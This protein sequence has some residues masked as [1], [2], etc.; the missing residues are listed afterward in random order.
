M[1]AP[2][3]KTRTGLRTTVGDAARRVGPTSIQP[4][5]LRDQRD[6]LSALNVFQY[7]QSYRLICQIAQGGMGKVYLAEALGVSGFTKTVGIKTIR[8]ELIDSRMFRDLFI[9]E[10][11]LVAD[12]VHENIQQ[13]Y[14]LVDMAGS[15]AIAMEWVHGVTFEDINSR[16]DERD[17]YLPPELAVFLTSR[18]ARALAY[19]HDK[20]DR[21]GQPMQ[22]V[23]RDVSPVNIFASWQGVVKLADFGIAKTLD[24]DANAQ[25]QQIMGKVPY[26]SPEQARGDVTDARTDIFAL[27]LVLFEMLTGEQVYPVEDVDEV[28]DLHISKRIPSPREWNPAIPASI[29]K[30]LARLCEFDPTKRYQSASE[31]VKDLEVFMY[32]GGYGPTNERLSEYLNELFPEVDKQR[33]LPEEV[34]RPR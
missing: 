27:G 23:H 34:I 31:V 25:G 16:L 33:L 3:N 15:Y 18:V 5:D 24:V 26:M 30:V 2:F 17:Q 20:R 11:K 29:D 14:G 6:A 8:R 4:E 22:I 19:A 21:L 7:V 10:A 13:V 28:I 1:K 12:L 32:S 9:D